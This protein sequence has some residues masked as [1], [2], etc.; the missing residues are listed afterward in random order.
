MK[1]EVNLSKT[2]HQTS[3]AGLIQ[4]NMIDRPKYPV[5]PRVD[6]G[7]FSPANIYG[8]NGA[9]GRSTNLALTESQRYNAA[10]LKN[11][12]PIQTMNEYPNGFS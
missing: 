8:T 1:N 9:Q 5:V 4:S 7:Q 6:L 10:L 11:V 2:P 12:A 3:G